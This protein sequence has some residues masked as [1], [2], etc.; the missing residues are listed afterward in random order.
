MTAIHR[1][2]P[3]KLHLAAQYFKGIIDPEFIE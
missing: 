3:P 2:R 1:H